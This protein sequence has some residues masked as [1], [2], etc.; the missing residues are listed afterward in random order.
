ML[1]KAKDENGIIRQDKIGTDVSVWARMRECAW[2]CG[3]VYVFPE[4]CH[5]ELMETKVI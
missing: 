1:F 4:I 2:A 5:V 3:R